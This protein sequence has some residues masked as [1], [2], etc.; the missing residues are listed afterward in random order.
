M[1]RPLPA[2]STEISTGMIGCEVTWVLSGAREEEDEKKRVMV[3]VEETASPT[4]VQLRPPPT[5]G[6][7]AEKQGPVGAGGASGPTGPTGRMAGR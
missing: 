1:A 2:N 6:Q 4:V 5:H 3:A 7:S